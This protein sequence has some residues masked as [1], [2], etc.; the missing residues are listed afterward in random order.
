MAGRS[1]PPAP[2]ATASCCLAFSWHNFSCSCVAMEESIQLK[3]N[4]IFAGLA[5]N[6]ILFPI[7]LTIWLQKT[8]TLSQ[9]SGLCAEGQRDYFRTL[10]AGTAYSTSAKL[11]PE[12]VVAARIV[13]SSG[14]ENSPKESISCPVVAWAH[15]LSTSTTRAEQDCKEITFNTASLEDWARRPVVCSPVEH[16]HR[17]SGPTWC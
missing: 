7:Q 2:T 5:F 9:R 12:G 15:S 14:K 13:R 8:R 3:G 1:N 10:D 16:K 4:Q 11:Q 6:S 17:G